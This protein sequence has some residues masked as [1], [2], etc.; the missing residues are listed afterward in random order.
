MKSYI[1]KKYGNPDVLKIANCPE[2]VPGSE[3]IRVKIGKIGLNYAEVQSRKGLYGWAPKLPYTLGMEAFGYV[4]MIGESVNSRK[5]GERVIVGCQYGT[6][7]EKI[8]IPE[9][10]A[11]SPIISFSDDE[12]S[13]FAVNYLTAW[14]A[15]MKVARLKSNDTVLV[16]AAAGGVGTAAVQI[17]KKF[18][19]NVIGT[20]SKNEKIEMLN[21]LG[22][23]MAI[24]YLHEDFEEIIKHKMN[25]NGVDVVLEVVGGDVFKKSMKLLNP[26]G[27][28]VVA[29]FA[30]LNLKKMNPISWVNTWKDI[31]RAKVAD[32]AESSTGL[33]ATHLGYLLN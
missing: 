33:L 30:S 19:C 26:F 7:A 20:A 3:E 17:A 4:D 6:Y 25:N 14:V 21:N 23:D 15:L 2:P 13:A 8:V 18:G 31:P 22:I 28:T 1:L 5:V 27:R 32:L 24:N 16:H 11:L 29:G 12:N 10:Q 9:R